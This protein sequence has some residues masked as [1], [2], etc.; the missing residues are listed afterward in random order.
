MFWEGSNMIFYLLY[1]IEKSRYS[2]FLLWL[3]NVQLHQLSAERLKEMELNE[4]KK[5]QVGNSSATFKDKAS[6]FSNKIAS[7]LVMTLTA[8]FEIG[9]FFVQFLDWW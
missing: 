1:S 6:N 9:A 7:N 5:N 3:Q 4:V 2:S 8:S